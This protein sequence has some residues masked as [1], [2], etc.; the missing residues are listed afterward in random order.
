MKKAESFVLGIALFLERKIFHRENES[1]PKF[2]HHGAAVVD[3]GGRRGFVVDASTGS[4]K[5][6]KYK[7]ALYDDDGERVP[8]TAM[9]SAVLWRA[10][11]QL[12]AMMD[13]SSGSG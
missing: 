6:R 10:E 1:Y 2:D 11:G 4:A 3:G 8:E 12:A 7:L 9:S 5:R 13:T